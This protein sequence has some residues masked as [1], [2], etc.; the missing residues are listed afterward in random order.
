MREAIAT[1][2][3]RQLR[4]GYRKIVLGYFSKDPNLNQKFDDFVQPGPFL[5]TLA[6]SHIVEI[7]Y[8]ELNG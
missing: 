5:P 4:A 6:V 3:L 2:N 7:H 8:G 1:N